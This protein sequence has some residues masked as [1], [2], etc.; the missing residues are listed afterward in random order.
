MLECYHLSIEN[1]NFSI[2]NQC[3]IMGEKTSH[4]ERLEDGVHD[5]DE[6]SGELMLLALLG[7]HGLG[8]G[9]GEVL[10]GLED[11]R[12]QDVGHHTEP[13]TDGDRQHW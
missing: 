6:G 4:E 3:K 5:W 9:G 13:A 1:R 8:G 2:E 12:A 10:D 7:G 11:F